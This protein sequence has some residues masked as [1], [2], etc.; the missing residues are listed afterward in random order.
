MDLEPLFYHLFK[1]I[2][3]SIAVEGIELANKVWQIAPGGKFRTPS[4]LYLRKQLKMDLKTVPGISI[5]YEIERVKG[6]NVDFT[7]T[8]LYQIDNAKLLDGYLYSS[9]LR[10]ILNHHKESIFNFIG[11]KKQIEKGFISSTWSSNKYFGHWIHDECTNILAAKDLSVTPYTTRADPYLHQSGYEKL[12]NL[13]SHYL[14]R[15]FIKKALLLDDST[16]NSYRQ[17]RLQ[18]LRDL[19][20]SSTQSSDNDYIYIGRGISGATNRGLVNE[21]ALI[22]KLKSSGFVIIEPETMSVGEILNCTMNA[23]V[24]MGVEGSSLSHGFLSVNPNGILVA[25]VPEYQFNNPYQDLCSVLDLRYGFIVGEKVKGGFSINFNDIDE[26]M[27][28]V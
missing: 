27:S 16:L 13:K 25:L 2:K 22:D 17:K 10:F 18:K 21:S 6:R 5:E 12:F 7:P 14:E 26:F 11:Q 15:A 3:P 4:A 1:Y 28:M 20:H 19:T 24:I 8:K 9:N 23:K